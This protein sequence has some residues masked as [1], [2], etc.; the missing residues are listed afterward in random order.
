MAFGDI[1]YCESSF[2]V[3]RE[4]MESFIS[5]HASISFA[6][7]VCFCL[8]IYFY[9]SWL[10]TLRVDGQTKTYRRNSK[11]SVLLWQW[12]F[13][14]RAVLTC[15]PLLV[16]LFVAASR[17]WDN[18]HR[19]LDIGFGAVIGIFVA[20]LMFKS[21]IMDREINVYYPTDPEAKTQLIEHT[22]VPGSYPSPFLLGFPFDDTQ[23]PRY[24]GLMG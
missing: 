12:R 19:P 3:I 18:A 4:G 21:W 7:I 5:G 1:K 6:G 15:T 8:W 11:L 14:L 10:M 16:P 2:S 20:L 23:V 9:F 22:E 24:H 17:V 13:L